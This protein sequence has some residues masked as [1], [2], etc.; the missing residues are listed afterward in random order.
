MYRFYYYGCFELLL[1]LLTTLFKLIARLVTMSLQN[2]TDV[3]VRQRLEFPI[4]NPINVSHMKINL[5]KF[6]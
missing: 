2:K 3:L 1:L 4:R 6:K 5:Y